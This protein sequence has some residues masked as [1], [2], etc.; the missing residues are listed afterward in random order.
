MVVDAGGTLAAA[1]VEREYHSWFGGRQVLTAGIAGVTVAAERR[2]EGLL[3]PLFDACLGDARDRGALV[4]TM[5]P[6]AAGIYRRFGYE[7]VGSLDEVEL[8]TADLHVPGDP[9]PLRR[10]TPAD[11]PAIRAA[12]TRWA[13][14]QH[15]PLT[16]TGPS[17]SATDT[18]LV[19]SFSGI[20]LAEASP[21]QV[22]GYVSWQRGA[23]YGESARLRVAD[24]I[25][26]DRASLAALLRSLAGH[27]S[28]APRTVIRT[29]GIE[30]WRLLLRSNAGTV[31]KRDPYALAVLD[32]QAFA[33]VGHPDGISA[34]LPFRWNDT[35]YVLTVADSSG[36]V[37]SADVPVGARTWTDAGLALTFAGTQSSRDQ[38]LLGHLSG[39]TADDAV[40]D[41][42]VSRPF[43][44]RD[45]F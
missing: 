15:G 31:V 44:V 32:V 23:G 5:F 42:L 2:G 7:V 36:H 24:L 37:Q 20:T 11:G 40:W 16:R 34:E 41:A 28:V 38:R 17:F 30:P 25:A 8:P 21:G 18:E 9:V 4:S 12:Y 19:E 29:S 10:A 43:H 35:G 39:S 27:A 26:D 45:Y 14:A 3:T 13:S 6:T 33:A 22:T 1:T